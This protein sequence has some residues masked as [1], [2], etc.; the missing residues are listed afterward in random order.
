MEKS[1]SW[2]EEV[3]EQLL[4]DMFCLGP[5]TPPNST[6]NHVPGKFQTV[7]IGCSHLTLWISIQ[8]YTYCLISLPLHLQL[9]NYLPFY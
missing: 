7:S 3:K 6:T 1:M 4:A 2:A 5:I 9:P 8:L